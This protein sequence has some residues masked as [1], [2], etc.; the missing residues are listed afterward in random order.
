M[1]YLNTTFIA[2]LKEAQF[3]KELLGAGATQIRRANYG[4]KGIYFQA[5]TSLSTGLE[6][7]GKLC[8]MLDHYIETGGSFPDFNYLKNEIGHKL[9]LLYDRSQ[10]VVARQSISLQYLSNLTDPVHVAMLKVLHDFAEGDRYS[11]V[12]LLVGSRQTNDPVA[13]WFN[14]VD[15]LLFSTRVSHRRRQNIA[16]NAAIVNRLMSAHTFV[17]HTSET[18]TEI[19]DLEEA[20]S[21]TGM[22]EAVVPYRQLCTLQI[23]RY[24]VEILSELGY[25]AQSLGKAEIPFFGE[26]FGAFN[27]EDSYMRTRKT[28]VGL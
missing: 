2:L 9:I 15:L 27:N 23:I 21:R 19:T 18:G 16:N 3:T 11:N 24:W 13:A 28:W 17:L 10:M 6:R 26:L 22:Y 8:L 12:N 4:S 14:E 20:S 5:F 25:K 1:A 7:I